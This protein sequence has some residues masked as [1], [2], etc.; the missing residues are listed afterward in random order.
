ML[1]SNVD[2]THFPAV[3]GRCGN[4]LGEDHVMKKKK[5][6]NSKAG[7]IETSAEIAPDTCSTKE[8]CGDAGAS[9]SKSKNAPKGK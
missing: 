3:D 8:N 1:Y 9:L 4:I 7:R 5:C 6:T 2:S